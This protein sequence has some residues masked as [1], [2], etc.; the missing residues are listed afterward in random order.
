MFFAVL[1]MWLTMVGSR[2]LLL[3]LIIIISTVQILKICE[4]I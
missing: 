3:I 2:V 1:A 4:N